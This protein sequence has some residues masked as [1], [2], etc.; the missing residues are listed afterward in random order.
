MS[1]PV[2]VH[3]TSM[4]I[5]SLNGYTVE[6]PTVRASSEPHAHWQIPW[7]ERQVRDGTLSRDLGPGASSGLNLL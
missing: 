5:E 1:V 3:G 6:K 4:L 2:P 7:A